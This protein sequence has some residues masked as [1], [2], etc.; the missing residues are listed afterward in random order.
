MKQ[1]KETKEEEEKTCC[2][3]CK[4]QR[5][6]TKE[7]EEEENCCY[8]CKIKYPRAHCVWDRFAKFVV[9]LVFVF[10]VIS[11]ICKSIN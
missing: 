9:V 7:E 11:K 5:K 10:C 6:E 1:G 2:Y 4:K 3:K 8:K